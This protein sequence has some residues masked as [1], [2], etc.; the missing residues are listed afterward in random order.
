RDARI[1]RNIR[2]TYLALRLWK[3][4]E[5]AELRALALDPHDA[6]AAAYLLSSRLNG[7]GDVDSAR[8]VFDDFPEAIKLLNL[9]GRGNAASVGLV[10][11]II[12]APVYLDVMQR[13]FTDAF[14]ALDKEVANNRAHLQQL[15]GRVALRVLAGQTAAA[16]SAGEEGRPLLETRLREQ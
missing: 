9:V 16:K 14:Q 8:R 2:Q 15:V 12:R 11:A 7:T 4:A 6:P 10:D 3:D 13:R 5:R 1:P